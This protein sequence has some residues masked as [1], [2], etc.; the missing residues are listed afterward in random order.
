MAAKGDRPTLPALALHDL[1]DR[2]NTY[3]R[4][5]LRMR[6]RNCAIALASASLL[7]APLLAQADADLPQRSASKA[8]EGV[9]LA[10]NG[11]SVTLLAAAAIAA[12][13]VVL[14]GDDGQAPAS[15]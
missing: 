11:L 14:G 7:A 1:E 13:I 5:E 15:P 2:I 6:V 9:H 3:L 10:G 4:G 12:G 8:A